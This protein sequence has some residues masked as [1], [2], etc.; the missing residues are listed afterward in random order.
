[1]FIAVHADYASTNA[2]G[3][4]IYSLRDRTAQRLKKS[5]K[6]EVAGT[7]LG[8]AERKALI[9]NATGALRGILA[10][11]AIREIEVTQRRTD[12][13]TQTVIHY[14]GQT[15]TMR[16]KPHREAGFKVI[17]TA[18]MPSILIELA[19]VSNRRDAARLTSRS[20]R[21]KVSSSIV[22]AVDNYFAESI[23]R[24]PM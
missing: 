19:Y 21:D 22:T 23:S 13:L 10:D 1:M 14:M 2:S 3:A 5:A 16:S 18:K 17:K 9:P 8:K 24:V 20:W 7:V 6:R 11:L 4:T 15:T 12:L